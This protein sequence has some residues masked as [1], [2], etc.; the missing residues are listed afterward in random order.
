VLDEF[1]RQ[2]HPF[3]AVDDSNGERVSGVMFGTG[4]PLYVLGPAAGDRELFSLLAWLLKDEFCCVFVDPPSIDWPVRS[5]T[6]LA[7]HSR[8]VLTAAQQLG[9]QR[10][11]IL[12]VEF[13]SAVALDLAV[14]NPDQVAA[15]I[16]LQAA[17]RISPSWMERGLHT[18]GSWLP[19]MIGGLPGWWNLQ[20]QNH[21]P[22]FPPFDNSRFD[23]LV[24]NVGRTRTSQLSRRMRL[25]SD[26]DFRAHL[27]SVS[28]RTLLID[29]EGEGPNVSRRMCEL[30]DGLTDARSEDMHSSGLYPYLTHPHRIAKLAR[31][32]LES[33][34]ASPSRTL[35]ASGTV[36]QL[37]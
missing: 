37:S 6:E 8:H 13:G 36:S 5:A 28:A 4:A 3:D 17:A 25:W 1:R 32:F 18:Y 23:F 20:R 35:E 2:C 15:L 31:T 24:Q 30:Q 22:W 27:G 26:L 34:P 19:G 12:G 9:H 21:R 7:R 14:N 29:T 11:A 16:L 10:F 33:V